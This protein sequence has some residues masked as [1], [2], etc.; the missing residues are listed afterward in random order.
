MGGS[1]GESPGDVELRDFQVLLRES[2][3]IARAGTLCARAG[4]IHALIGPNGAG[5]TSLLRG[6]AGILPSNGSIRLGGREIGKW[7]HARRTEVL[8]YQPQGTL[9]GDG[10]T[11]HD[12]VSASTWMRGRSASS[13]EALTPSERVHAA[14][15][16]TGASHLAHRQVASLSGGEMARTA[17]AATLASGAH[18]L[19]LD[20]PVSS[21]DISA[22]RGLYHVIRGLV[23]QGRCSVIVV[24]HDLG[25]ARTFADD[26]TLIAKGE[27]SLSGPIAKVFDSSQLDSAYGCTL[28]RVDAGGGTWA[29]VAVGGLGSSGERDPLSVNNARPN[30]AGVPLTAQ[31][32]SAERARN[33]A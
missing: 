13:G 33:D 18:W 3:P 22:A 7:G 6:M 20:E 8:A 25:L 32:E 24:E 9:T 11:V 23:D 16:L 10:I 19:L 15:S 27:A 28:K 26:A 4:R 30:D 31:R 21:A 14:I 12:F 29:V 2:S 5:K 1:D 17:L